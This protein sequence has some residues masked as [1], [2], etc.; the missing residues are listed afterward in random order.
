MAPEAPGVLSFAATSAPIVVVQFCL[1]LVSVVTVMRV[2]HSL[3]AEALAGIS[4]GNLTYNLTGLTLIMAPMNALDTV[5]PQSMG[6]GRKVDVGL[7][8]LRSLVVA[9]GVCV[10]ASLFWWNAEAVLLGLGQPP[11]AASL[12]AAFL[13]GLLPVLPVF[14]AL[15]ALRRFL[16]AQEVTWPPLVASVIGVAGHACW[17]GP[18]VDALG[19]AG[20]AVSL[21]LTFSTML[22]VLVAVVI[23]RRP[24][25]PETWPGL[26]SALLWSDVRAWT[27]F[28]K[29]SFAAMLAL[30]EWVFWELVCFLAGRFGSKPL[31]VHAMAYSILPLLTMIPHGLSIGLSNAVGNLLGA[32]R[33]AE[34]KRLA[35]LASGLTLCCA[36]GYASAMYAARDVVVRL[37]TNDAEVI[38]Q[39]RV[40]WPLVCIDL[41]GDGMFMLLSGLCRGLGL[42]QRAAGCIFFCLWVCGLPSMLLGARSVV[43]IWRVMVP[44]YCMLDACL[45]LSACTTSWHR[46]AAD[47]QQSASLS[48]ATAEL[49][50]P[51]LDPQSGAAL[52]TADNGTAQLE[53]STS[54]T[55]KKTISSSYT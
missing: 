9:G 8:C 16:Y 24:H 51:P 10:P 45:V 34:A 22:A 1:V 20:G 29:L 49:T 41:V 19:Y 28:I 35:F 40:V 46:L 37:F 30:S 4:L 36:L 18:C 11:H 53:T 43:D 15:E 47:L 26:N 14:T 5:A 48:S 17:V 6:A 12:A 44:I 50:I 32:S 27:S 55:T 42:Q 31:A 52:E 7:A 23:V 21:L 38:A 2:G 25:D 39:A 54:A 33:V 13:R 3:G